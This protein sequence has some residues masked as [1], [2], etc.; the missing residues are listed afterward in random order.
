VRGWG[1]GAERSTCVFSPSALK[2]DMSSVPKMALPSAAEA[3]GAVWCL[4]HACKE[5]FLSLSKTIFH[6]C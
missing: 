4:R 2:D 5:D 6:L 1:G 3:V